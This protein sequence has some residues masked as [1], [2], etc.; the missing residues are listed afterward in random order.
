MTHSLRALRHAHVEM[1]LTGLDHTEAAF[2]FLLIRSAL[3][4]FQNKRCVTV[5][6][7]TV[8]DGKSI[9]HSWF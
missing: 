1:R 7:L 4:R 3:K 2:V 6:Y 9:L 8:T 5:K